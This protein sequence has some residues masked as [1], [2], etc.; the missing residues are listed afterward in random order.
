[1]LAEDRW[2]QVRVVAP[3][4]GSAD[5]ARHALGELGP[6]LRVRF[7]TVEVLLSELGVPAL[8]RAGRAAEPAGWLMP[9]LEAEVRRLADAGQLA[10]YGK[11]LLRPGWGPTLEAALRQV[12]QARL[13]HA[14]LR[15]IDA[16]EGVR[17]RLVI[18]ADLAEAIAAQRDAAGLYARTDVHIAAKAEATQGGLPVHRDQATV[19]IGDRS[20]PP[21]AFEAFEAWCGSRP[22]VRVALH[23]LE[24]L[25]PAPHGIR[26][27]AR[28]AETIHVPSD[29]EPSLRRTVFSPSAPDARPSGAKVEAVRNLDEHR[30]VRAAVRRALDAI[31]GGAALDRIAFVLPDPGEAALLREALEKANIPATWLTGPPLATSG[32]ARL[33][34]HALAVSD[35]QSSAVDWYR[36]LRTP[37]LR[38]RARLGPAAVRG[39][40]RWRAL[41]SEV[42]VPRDTARIQ[43]ELEA[44]EAGLD[45]DEDAH[46]L[47]SSQALSQSITALMDSFHRWPDRAT[48]AEHARAWATW[49][50]RWASRRP[51]RL[52][53]ETLLDGVGRAAGPELTRAGA[54]LVLERLLRSTPWLG[55]RLDEPK[56]R[57]LPPMEMVG[58]AFDLVCVLGMSEGR[59]PQ[60]RSE[61]PLLTDALVHTIHEATGVRLDDADTRRENERRRFAATLTAVE[62]TLWL[63]APAHE[64]RTGRPLAPGNLLFDVKAALEG[65]A[66]SLAE[67]EAWLERPDSDAVGVPHEESRAICGAER[68]LVQAR[69]RPEDAAAALSTHAVA[70]RLLALHRSVDRLRARPNSAPLDAWTGRIDPAL[71]S[72]RLGTRTLTPGAVQRLLQ[73]PHRFFFQDL[74]GAWPATPLPRETDPTEP[75]WLRQAVQSALVEAKAWDALEAAPSTWL[76]AILEADSSVAELSDAARALVGARFEHDLGVVGAGAEV[77]RAATPLELPE[78]QIEG[79]SWS[80]AAMEVWQSDTQLIAFT[81]TKLNKKL[82]KLEHDFTSACASLAATPLALQETI[83]IGK[84]ERTGG[85]PSVGVGDTSHL[86]IAVDEAVRHAYRLAHAGLW[87]FAAGNH[88]KLEREVEIDTSSDGAIQRLTGEGASA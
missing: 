58:G 75:W 31:H 32:P 13:H 8:V 74:L 45:S 1:M 19:V 37:T 20:L 78:T 83:G 64:L 14:Q 49:L 22:C 47:A 3:S 40:G 59:F 23:P 38:L 50:R 21:A 25:P 69:R 4:A 86:A 67:L 57:V 61:D 15:D 77:L 82:T 71:L 29:D 5:L 63:S 11:T 65:R 79:T 41:L 88:F 24:N 27:A 39:R 60:A 12:E 62:G 53:V 55:G 68:R 72:E 26:L 35:P 70:R 48:F 46:K 2:A 87:P 44:L 30:E 18:L 16:P 54:R 76:D 80:L 17:E 84:A 7:S 34:L 10:G 36:L 51:E 42:G 66:V 6:F 81:R 9:T 56:V 28:D 73:S 43:A 85:P 33:L 52:A